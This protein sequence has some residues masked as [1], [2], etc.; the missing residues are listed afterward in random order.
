MC[1]DYTETK[2]NV[3]STDDNANIKGCLVVYPVRVILNSSLILF[4][5]CHFLKKNSEVFVKKKMQINMYVFG[6][7]LNRIAKNKIRIG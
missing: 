5:Y 7:L 4:F 3:I 2:I 6:P 1:A